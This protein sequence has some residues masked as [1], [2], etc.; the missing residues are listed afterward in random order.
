MSTLLDPNSALGKSSLIYE[1]FPKG[2]AHGQVRLR[3]G[4]LS[5]SGSKGRFNVLTPFGLSQLLLSPLKRAELH[6]PIKIPRRERRGYP[7]AKT[8]EQDMQ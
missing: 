6:L 4:H 3:R 7:P 1:A 2:E 8:R 5:D